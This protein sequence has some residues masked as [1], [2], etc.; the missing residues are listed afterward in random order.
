M[1]QQAIDER[2][3]LYFNKLSALND[4]SDEETD[5]N[6][7]REILRKSKKRSRSPLPSFVG[8]FTPERMRPPFSFMKAP[9]LNRTTSAP[10]S[11][12]LVKE[13]SPLPRISAVRRSESATPSALDSPRIIGTPLTAATSTSRPDSERR[14]VSN[15][16]RGSGPLVLPYSNGIQSLLGKNM[17]GKER[18]ST[19]G[20]APGKKKVKKEASIKLVPDNQRIFKDLT[21]YYVP[22]PDKSPVRRMRI[23]KAREYGATWTKDFTPSITH[24]IAEKGLNYK[25]VMGF[26]NLDNLPQGIFL[27]TDDYPTLCLDSHFLLDPTQKPYTICQDQEAVKGETAIHNIES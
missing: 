17:L 22:P 19:N 21:F 16:T 13:T 18:K 15:P 25:E 8:E 6:D 1:N 10:V 26:L 23:T 5:S 14:R 11:S 7:V 9:T 20:D 3:E 4:S 27:V 12:S 24:I 2:K